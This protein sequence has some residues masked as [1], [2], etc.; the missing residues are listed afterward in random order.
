MKNP[1]PKSL[2]LIAAGVLIPM[3]A[4]R[5]ARQLV[6]KGYT[7]VTDKPAPQNPASP[8]TELKQA[9]IWTIVTGAIGGL[10]RMTS[11]RYLAHT[12]VP[13]EGYDMDEAIQN[14]GE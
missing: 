10:A 1:E 9:I 11:Q 4:A 6:G 8:D 13:A 7:A 3:I 12:S 2:L 5:S 14:V